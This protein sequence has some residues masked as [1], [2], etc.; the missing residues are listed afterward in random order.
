MTLLLILGLGVLGFFVIFIIGAMVTGYI[1]ENRTGAGYIL[2]G[3][4]LGGALIFG[5]LRHAA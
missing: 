4:L 5:I 2:L 1:S 3:A